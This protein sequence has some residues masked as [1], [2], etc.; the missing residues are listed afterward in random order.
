MH[1]LFS[2]NECFCLLT[3]SITFFPFTCVYLFVKF[4]KAL[5]YLV[6]FLIYF[7]SVLTVLLL[8]LS[9]FCLLVVS[10]WLET[11]FAT[12][13]AD[14]YMSVCLFGS[15]SLMIRLCGFSCMLQFKMFLHVKNQ[16]SLYSAYVFPV[17]G[18][19]SECRYCSLISVLSWN[20]CY[21]RCYIVH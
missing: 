17:E 10:L 18:S 4:K 2:L 19:C 1:S 3:A 8:F 15:D 11:C 14:L 9:V 20:I 16:R 12:S 21:L 13:D 6:T 5:I 7:S